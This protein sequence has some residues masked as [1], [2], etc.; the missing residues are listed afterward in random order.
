MKEL[1][2]TFFHISCWVRYNEFDFRRYFKSFQYVKQLLTDSFA[3]VR[4]TEF[5]D[6]LGENTPC[7][8]YQTITYKTS[9]HDKCPNK[10]KLTN[11]IILSHSLSWVIRM[12]CYTQVRLIGQVWWP[13]IRG[14]SNEST[15]W[16]VWHDLGQNFVSS[17]IDPFLELK[18]AGELDLQRNNN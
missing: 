18:S 8:I 14:Y 11:S 9:L 6:T 7:N 1:K 16:Q 10:N 4:P 2:P 15:I 13:N 3:S 12:G 17:F 5:L